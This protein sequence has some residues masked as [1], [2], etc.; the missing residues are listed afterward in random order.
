MID[1]LKKQ[2]PAFQEV[3][4]DVIEE[5]K[6]PERA[7]EYDYW[8]VPTLFVDGKKIMEGAPSIEKIEE[9]FNEALG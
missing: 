2:N 5:S 6:E 3:P 4:I 7:D 8:Y 1:A 9:A